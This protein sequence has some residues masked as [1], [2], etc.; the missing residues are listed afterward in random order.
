MST[1]E[2]ET[3]NRKPFPSGRRE[4]AGTIVD[5]ENLNSPA[6]PEVRLEGVP[7]HRVKCRSCR[8]REKEF[9]SLRTDR[10]GRT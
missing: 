2:E 9:L 8:Q 5:E 7:A 6:L 3:F 4:G 1:Q 10:K